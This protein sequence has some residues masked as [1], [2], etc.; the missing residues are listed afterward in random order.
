MRLLASVFLLF[1]L[2]SCG[3]KP[4][5]VPKYFAPTNTG[6]TVLIPFEPGIDDTASLVG[7]IC[8]PDEPGR[9]R[10]VVINHGAPSDPNRKADMQPTGCDTEA[11]Q[12]FTD[13]NY[14][15]IFALR[16]GFGH[17]TGPVVE[18]TGGCRA[19]NYFRSGLTGAMDID[20]ILRYGL[21]LPFVQPTGAI[22]IGQSTGGWATIAYDSV[23]NPKASIFI[24]FAGGRG[25]HAWPDPP[26]NCRPDLLIA[27]AKRFG[28]SSVAPMLWVYAEN[29]TFF[30]QELVKEMHQAYVRAGG[31]AELVF[32]PPI[33]NEGHGLFYAPGGSLLWGPTVERYIAEQTPQ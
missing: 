13:R 26:T 5:F 6:D 30:P 12:F 9:Y 1:A 22:V 28:Q 21:A 15:V 14:V 23:D 11:A 2:A 31:R 7:R 33:G 10:L 4:D 20:A 16:R 17:S 18:D 8:R 3:S 29:D 32:T 24:S 19:P 25:G 27:D